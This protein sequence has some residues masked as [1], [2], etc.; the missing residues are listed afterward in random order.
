MQ[1]KEVHVG[2]AGGGT[3][4]AGPP[5]RPRV[6]FADDS[7]TQ[8]ALVGALLGESYAVEAVESGEAALRTILANPPDVILCD[9]RMPGIPGDESRETPAC[10]ASP[11]S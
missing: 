1:E 5:E 7:A 8:R 4:S 2:G 9:L 10:G 6:V 3:D 11:S